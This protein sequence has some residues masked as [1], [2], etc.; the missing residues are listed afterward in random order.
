MREVS[1]QKILGA[2]NRQERPNLSVEKSLEQGKNFVDYSTRQ[3][4]VC[5]GVAADA[6]GARMDG[7]FSTSK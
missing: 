2:L 7:D 4:G 3:C 6:R 5:F 1:I